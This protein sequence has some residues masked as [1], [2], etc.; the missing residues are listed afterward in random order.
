MVDP[1]EEGGP[2]SS[3]APLS[4]R[5]RRVY[6]PK[7]WRLCPK[8]KTLNKS[9]L[10]IKEVSKPSAYRAVWVACDLKQDRQHRQ[11]LRDC[12]CGRFSKTSSKAAGQT[13]ISSSV[14]HFWVEVG[15]SRPH[16]HSPWTYNFIQ[17]SWC[18]RWNCCGRPIG[19]T[20]TI[21]ITERTVAAVSSMELPDQVASNVER[22]IPWTIRK[23]KIKACFR[24][25]PFNR[26]FRLRELSGDS[27]RSQPLW[28]QTF[29]SWRNFWLECS[30][31][32]ESLE[33]SKLVD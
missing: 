32:T 2:R 33:N 30:D 13:R 7:G 9:A 21:Q 5:F 28:P 14:V 27:L 12:E 8:G 17:D 25:I 15:W 22:D 1:E 20:S 26:K 23:G 24:D 6:P 31:R 29:G 18:W 11:V 16:N 19:V 10:M 3:L 4:Q